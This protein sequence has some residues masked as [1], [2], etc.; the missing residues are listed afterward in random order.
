MTHALLLPLLKTPAVV[1]GVLELGE[2][3]LLEQT[4]A[5]VVEGWQGLGRGPGAAS[6]L[7]TLTQRTLRHTL[8][9][10]PWSLV[11]DPANMVLYRWVVAVAGLPLLLLVLGM[12]AAL[13]G[14]GIEPCRL[15]ASPGV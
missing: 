8:Q 5:G 6:T 9:P 11:H 4:V 1:L 7:G 12:V 2:A 3:V 14:H 10:L 13:L 15:L